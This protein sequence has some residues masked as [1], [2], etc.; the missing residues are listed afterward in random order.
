MKALKTSDPTIEGKDFGKKIPKFIS[1][2]E[3][4]INGCLKK[5]DNL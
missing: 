3:T 1:D 2:M 5:L 4:E